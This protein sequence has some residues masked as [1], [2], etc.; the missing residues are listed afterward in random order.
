MI[1]KI[2]IDEGF[3]LAQA[4]E[5]QN[6]FNELFNTDFHLSLKGEYLLLSDN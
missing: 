3:S 5:T 2:Y 1:I 6:F 4:E